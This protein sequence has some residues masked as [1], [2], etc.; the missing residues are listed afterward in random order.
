MLVTANFGRF[1]SLRS[2]FTDPSF[3][4]HH[5]D[6]ERVEIG[7]TDPSRHSGIV[8]IDPLHLFCRIHPPHDDADGPVRDGTTQDNLPLVEGCLV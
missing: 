8:L 4:G 7:V 2:L 5:A 3:S 6:P 1:I